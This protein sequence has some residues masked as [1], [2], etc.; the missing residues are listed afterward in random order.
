[1]KTTRRLMMLGAATLAGAGKAA[2]ARPVSPA[3]TQSAAAAAPLCDLL[4][5]GRAALASSEREG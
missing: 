5:A 3:P 1:M 2:S 4:A